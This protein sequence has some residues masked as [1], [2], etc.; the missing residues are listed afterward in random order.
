MYLATTIPR[1]HH[2]P[3]SLGTA[4]AALRRSMDAHRA[5]QYESFPKIEWVFLTTTG[6]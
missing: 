1:Y 3:T 6:Y 5:Q 4:Y 2:P